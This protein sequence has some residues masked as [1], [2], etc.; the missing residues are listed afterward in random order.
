MK[1]P[2]YVKY[3]LYALGVYGAYTLV[4]GRRNNKKEIEAALNKWM[5]TL[6]N[7]NSTSEDIASLYAKDGI[8]LGT[9]ASRIYDGPSDIKLYFDG[10][11]ESNPCGEFDKIIIQDYGMG[12]VADGL[13]TFTL[14]PDT[15]DEEIVKARFTFV[16]KEVG[17]L[18]K[19]SSHH[20]SVD[21]GFEE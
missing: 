20:S 9:V 4:K 6:C 12:A 3:G 15:E 10:F 13:Y 16:L 5:D 11:L 14:N 8:L 1:L 17:G 2:I 19:I 7:P 21:P 18:W